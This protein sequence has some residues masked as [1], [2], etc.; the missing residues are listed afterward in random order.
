MQTP[1]PLCNNAFS[2]STDLI[3][4]RTLSQWDKNDNIYTDGNYEIPSVLFKSGGDCA[5]S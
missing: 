4:E 5:V 1:D 2:Q 3:M